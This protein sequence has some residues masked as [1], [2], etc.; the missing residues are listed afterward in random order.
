MARGS[1]HFKDEADGS[2]VS[3]SITF[4]ND[5]NKLI[6][7]VFDL[8]PAH[9]AAMKLFEQLKEKTEQKKQSPG[10]NTPPG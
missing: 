9:Q 7:G 2:G 4:H 6:F 8:T 10:K 5:K 3:I 1:I